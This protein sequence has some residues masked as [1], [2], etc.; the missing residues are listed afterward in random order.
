MKIRGVD[1]VMF[2]VTDL[3]AAARFYRDV[4][5]LPQEIYSEPHQWAEFDCGDVTLALKG[6]AAVVEGGTGVRLALAV[7]D[8][9]AAFAELQGK[10]ARVVSRPVDH[11]VCSAFEVLDPDGNVI[12]LHHRADGTAGRPGGRP[13]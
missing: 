8:V 7:D 1:F 2:E 9:E 3:A 5:G 11:G 4:L 12:L 13:P 6:G 10:G